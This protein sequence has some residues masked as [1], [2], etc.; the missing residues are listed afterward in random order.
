MAD[1]AEIGFRADTRELKDAKAVLNEIRPAADSA[2]SSVN[3]LGG[4]M[5]K[6][7]ASANAMGTG[8]TAAAAG[9][10]SLGKASELAN[11]SMGHM[12]NGMALNSRS[13]REL[14]VVSRELA[15]GNFTR[16]I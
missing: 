5:G 12:G 8:A 11:A 6:V 3:K 7:N 15:A 14:M 16:L 9:V 13:I 4:T 1:I 2:E 10:N